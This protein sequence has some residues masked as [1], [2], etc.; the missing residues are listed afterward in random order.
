M[1][2]NYSSENFYQLRRNLIDYLNT[3][4]D[5]RLKGLIK[6]FLEILENDDYIEKLKRIDSFYLKFNNWQNPNDA[7]NSNLLSNA[8]VVL[9][10]VYNKE[11]DNRFSIQDV[12]DSLF[13][14]LYADFYEAEF[15]MTEAEN[16][17]NS[18]LSKYLSEMNYN[19]DLLSIDASKR[20]RHLWAFIPKSVFE[21]YFKNYVNEDTLKAVR[22]LKENENF[23]KAQ[24]SANNSLKSDIE[25]IR[26]ELAEQ[27]S[28]FNFIG[29]SNGFK[30]LK[31]QK[32]KEL[33]G[34]RRVYW[35]LMLSIIGL[36][37]YKLYWTVN[38]L[39]EPNPNLQLLIV[40]SISFVLMLLV[41][42]YFFRISL[43]NIKSIRS[44]ILQID[45]RL[46]LCQ[47]IHNYQND[48]SGFRNAE[49]KDSLDKFEAVIFSPIVATDDK[50]PTTFEG[51]E[52]LSGLIG[53]VKGKTP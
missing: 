46:T 28:E 45:L 30:S 22:E 10:N 53:L 42:I 1:L 6:T 24:I 33:N 50:I 52:Q 15:L 26:S 27:K 36:I 51:I 23:I 41:V 34:E 19:A 11:V 13:L 31:E 25:T 18:F 29:L 4:T 9:F 35:I 49:I 3:H 7:L 48:T 38:Y 40:V 32:I 21:N 12:I 8:N 47:F 37:I 17:T 20:L 16:Q 2:F 39:N 14:V 5:E 43:V 44:Q